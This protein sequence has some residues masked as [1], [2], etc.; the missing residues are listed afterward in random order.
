MATSFDTKKA[1]VCINGVANCAISNL[2]IDGDGKGDANY[3]FVGLAFWNAG[4]TITS[5]DVTRVRD[6]IFSGAQHGVG[7]YANND[8]G[9]PYTVTINGMNVT[10]Y[11]KNALALLGTGLTVDLDNVTTQGAG[12][13]SITAQNGIQIGNGANGTV[14]NCTINDVAY[15]GGYWTATGFLLQGAGTVT[16]NNV[17][18]DG[19]QT[20]AYF[21]DCNVNYNG[22]AIT[23]PLGDGLWVYPSIYKGK[24]N[25]PKLL[26][27]AIEGS[28]YKGGNK[29]TM[30][31]T[32]DNNTMT[33]TDTP[34]V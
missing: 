4:G 3:E 26:P 27:S 21:I 24:G 31:V 14:D 20:S 11:Q 2:T 34:G 16:A 7:V 33:G 22:S 10:D 25:N 32:F 9:G 23:N 12:A 15:T 30:N 13:T 29:A 5:V 6:N 1:V 19:C 18:V 8:T 28:E 17:D